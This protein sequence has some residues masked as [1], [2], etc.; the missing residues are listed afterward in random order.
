MAYHGSITQ[1]LTAPNRL[2]GGT[3]DAGHGFTTAN[4]WLMSRGD[5]MWS[6]TWEGLQLLNCYQLCNSDDV[7]I[8][9]GTRELT[10]SV[11]SLSWESWPEGHLAIRY[12][13]ENMSAACV[14]CFHISISINIGFVERILTDAVAAMQL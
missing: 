3:R 4:G 14:E 1:W 5:L 9:E 7:G 11:G 13:K 6:E 8:S 10:G 12:Q 2:L